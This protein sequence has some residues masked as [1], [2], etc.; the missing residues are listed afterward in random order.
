[1][2]CWI[3][4]T[5]GVETTEEQPQTGKEHIFVISDP[6]QDHNCSVHQVQELINQYLIEDLG[7]EVRKMHQFTGGCAAEYKSEHHL[8]DLFCSV[9]DYGY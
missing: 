5:D 1:M 2:G 3:E 9:A 8:G 6:W 4:A 7:C